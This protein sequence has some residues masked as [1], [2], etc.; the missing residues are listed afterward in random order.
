MSPSDLKTLRGTLNVGK[1]KGVLSVRPLEGH[2]KSRVK[3]DN[4]DLDPDSETPGPEG[5]LPTI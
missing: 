2:V 3:R 5:S 1:T 4:L